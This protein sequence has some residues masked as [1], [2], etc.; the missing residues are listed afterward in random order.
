MYEPY[1]AGT[2]DEKMFRVVK[3]RA[4][5]FD[6]VMGRSVGN[7]ENSTDREESRVALHP[8]ILDAMRMD[9]TST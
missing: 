1:L 7:D 9:L 6:I 4:G 5:W 8:S 2:H 3:A